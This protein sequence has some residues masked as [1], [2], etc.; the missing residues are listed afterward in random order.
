MVAGEVARFARRG[1]PVGTSTRIETAADASTLCVWAV[2]AGRFGRF[3][4]IARCPSLPQQ[5]TQEL[6]SGDPP[7]SFEGLEP[8]TSSLP[9]TPRGRSQLR[10]RFWLVSSVRSPERF[11][12]DCHRLHPGDS[13]KAPSFVDG[14]HEESRARRGRSRRR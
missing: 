10:Q 9:C 2:V 8:S 7:K 12:A 11:A 5:A 6:S 13:I 3:H 1:Y 14:I 4:A